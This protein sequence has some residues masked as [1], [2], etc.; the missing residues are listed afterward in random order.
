MIL[1]SAGFKAAFLP[2]LPHFPF[3]FPLL[4]E[5][6]LPLC[7]PVPGDSGSAVDKEG[8]AKNVDPP[9]DLPPCDTSCTESLLGLL[10][11]EPALD[12]QRLCKVGR[13]SHSWEIK[14]DAGV[15]IK[16]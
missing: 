9:A 5:Y 11:V 6:L 2:L 1:P 4:V 13:P 8:P 12:L 15:E 14:R 3:N 10:N 16:M 7:F